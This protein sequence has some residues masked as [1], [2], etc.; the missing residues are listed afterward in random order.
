MVGRGGIYDGLHGDGKPVG[1]PRQPA[2]TTPSDT[3]RAEFEA[4]A[5]KN[6]WSVLRF[7]KGVYVIW[8]TQTAWLAFQFAWQASAE[9][10]R[11]RV[12][13]EVRTEGVGGG[14][15]GSALNRTSAPNPNLVRAQHPDG[16]PCSCEQCTAR[17][18]AA[19]QET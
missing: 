8:S 5:K 1:E 2:M 3:M 10:E 9:A 15:E 7:P 4:L 6:A 17:R 13:I 18:L 19:Q 11:G 16:V 12:T 14:K